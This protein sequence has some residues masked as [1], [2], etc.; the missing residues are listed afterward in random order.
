[1]AD[2]PRR[3]YYKAGV[4]NHYTTTVG[5]SDKYQELLSQ[6]PTSSAQMRTE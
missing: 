2:R 6:I 5:M 1:M 3:L 4:N